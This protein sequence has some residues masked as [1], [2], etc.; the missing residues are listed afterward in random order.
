M[1]SSIQALILLLAVGLLIAAERRRVN[2]LFRNGALKDEA[3]RRIERDLGMR[4]AHLA[5]QRPPGT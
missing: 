5:Q 4:E 1:T 3:R 2:E